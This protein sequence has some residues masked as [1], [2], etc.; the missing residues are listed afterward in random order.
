MLSSERM[1]IERFEL[2]DAHNDA[3]LRPRGRYAV[4]AL[5]V[6]LAAIATTLAWAAAE[7]FDGWSHA[8]VLGMIVFT[9]IGLMIAISPGRSGA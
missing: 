1:Q 8:I 9:T 6:V 7:T 3:A 2:G 4:P 5:T